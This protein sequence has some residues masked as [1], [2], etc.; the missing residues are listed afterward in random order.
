M[1][2][3]I[4]GGASSGK[5]TFA[6]RLLLESHRPHYYI[7]TMRSSDDECIRKIEK[8]RARRLSTDIITIEKPTDIQDI[9]FEENGTALL[10]CLTTLLANEMFDEY[11]N[12]RDVYQ[13]IIDGIESL[14]GQTN[15][16]IVVSNDVGR[17]FDKDNSSSTM[18]YIKTAGHL[19]CALAA[20]F[21]RVYEMV[22]GKEIM[23]K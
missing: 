16:L 1:R 12:E 19:N 15:N 13:K 21:D 7:A 8:H 4:V 17:G 18:D 10:E 5:S 20:S 14:S 3:L 23:I 22:C 2:I 6:E 9:Q 11:G